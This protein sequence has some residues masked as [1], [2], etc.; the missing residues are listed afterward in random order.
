VS[1]KQTVFAGCIAGVVAACGGAGLEGIGDTMREAG[2]ALAGVGGSMVAGSG[3]ASG[4]AAGVGGSVAMRRTV[5][6]MLAAAGS[7]VAHAGR[8]MAGAAAGSGGGVAGAAAQEPQADALPRPHWILRD[9][10]GTPMQVDATPGYADTT[11]GFGVQ[12]DCVSITH[13]G[14][15]RIGLGYMLST[16]KVALPGECNATGVYD[17]RPSWRSSGALWSFAD[18]QCETPLATSAV[19][20]VA[21]GDQLY[22]SQTGAPT[23]PSTLYR[24]VS[25]S[26]T[27]EA[28]AN[29][30]NARMWTWAPMPSEVA[31]LLSQAPYTLE[32]A[33]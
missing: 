14:Q 13:A 22:H 28:F 5:G 12:P 32:L 17:Q 24:W 7:S 6:G 9:K 3:G 23:V 18:A 11:P 25:E 31:G 16:G 15:R 26:A 21:I 27:C 4:S 1:S 10:H 29:T 2:E 19:F 30:S 33:Y 8:A 20:I